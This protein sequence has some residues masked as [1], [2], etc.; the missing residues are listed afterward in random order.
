MFGI[1][2]VFCFG[3]I[4]APSFE[5]SVALWVAAGFIIGLALPAYNSLM[6]EQIPELRGTVMAWGET[7]QFI[8]QALGSSIGAAILLTY[9]FGGLGWFSL[10]GV[11]AAFLLYFFATDPTQEGQFFRR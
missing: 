9:G 6:L 4:F 3:Y 8:A 11:I 1:G 7:S 2:S 5:V 10:T